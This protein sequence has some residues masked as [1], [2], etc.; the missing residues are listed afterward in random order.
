PRPSSTRTLCTRTRSRSCRRCRFR[1]LSSRRSGGRSS[2][3][4]ICRARRIHLRLAGSTRVARS[5]SRPAAGRKCRRSAS[6]PPVTRSRATGPRRSRKAGSSRTSGRSCSRLPGQSPW[7]SRRQTENRLALERGNAELRRRPAQEGADEQELVEPLGCEV[8]RGLESRLRKSCVDL[9]LCAGARGQ[10]AHGRDASTGD[11]DGTDEACL[12]RRC[13]EA[14]TG[15]A[16][17]VDAA[18]GAHDAV[19]RLDPIAQ[20]GSVL[21]AAALREVA[22]ACA[23]P[24]QRELGLLQLFRCCSVE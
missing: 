12:C 22:Q 7:K 5:C 16:Q 6:S 17:L 21:V 24:R 2:S 10:R 20:P 19:E 13:E 11:E 15:A 23:S 4:A 14:A 8:L 9:E 18:K 3:P 1:I